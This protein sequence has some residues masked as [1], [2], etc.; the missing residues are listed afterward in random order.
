MN[1]RDGVSRSHP[2]HL[3]ALVGRLGIRAIRDTPTLMFCVLSVQPIFEGAEG[4][5]MPININGLSI[6]LPSD[7]C[8]SLLDLLR[9]HLDLAGTKRAVTRERVG[10]AR[11]WWTENVSFPAS[12]WQSSM[13]A[14]R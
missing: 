14:A 12:H 7:T 3:L 8:V 4:H 10:R 11:C 6:D 9:D 1:A 5:H 13:K 2:L